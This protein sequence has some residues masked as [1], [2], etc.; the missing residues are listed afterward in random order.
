MKTQLRKFKLLIES[1]KTL[2]LLLRLMFNK[3]L[4]LL[5]L[6]IK[7]KE[8]LL[9][10]KLNLVHLKELMFS[11]SLNHGLMK[12]ILKLL[13]ILMFLKSLHSLNQ[14]LN[15]SE[16][17]FQ[18]LSLLNLFNNKIKLNKLQ[19][20]NLS[21]DNL[22]PLNQEVMNQK[23]NLLQDYLIKLLKNNQNNNN[24]LNQKLILH[25]L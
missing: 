13:K 3:L 23:K 5:N 11:Q 8:M 20:L 12:N 14:D 6:L 21:S 9:I 25:S 22:N 18:S 16:E 7:L 2:L 24:L 1:T 19:D 15:Q 10:L 4:F 17:M